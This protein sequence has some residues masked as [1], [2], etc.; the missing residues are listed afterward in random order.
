MESA[1]STGWL[2]VWLN[3]ERKWRGN[4]H[5]CLSSPLGGKCSS[6]NNKKKNSFFGLKNDY[7]I[8]AAKNKIKLHTDELWW[9]ID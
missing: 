6:E 5:F 4:R 2:D 9:M 3:V 1:D 7:G 8:V